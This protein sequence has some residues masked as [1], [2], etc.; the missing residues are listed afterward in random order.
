MR[1]LQVTDKNIKGLKWH[2]FAMLLPYISE[3]RKRISLAISFMVLAKLASVSLPFFLKY[4]VD[5]L[6][7]ETG[8]VAK[9][10]FPPLALVLAYGFARFLN[11][12]FNELRD[13]VFGRVTE[14]TMRKVGLKTFI[15]LHSLDLDF[16]LNRRT[17]GLS[18][19]IERG[20]NGISFLM[21]F[22]IFNIL[23]TL[24]EV[25]L[26]VCLLFY[27]YGIVYAL[28]TLFS[29]IAYVCFS[30]YATEW[31]TRFVR[32]E[33]EADSSS[34]TRAIDSLM[35]YE[36]V[37]YFTN[38]NHEAR[39]YDHELMFWE[40]ARRKN[41]LTL[42][43]LNAGQALI[44]AITMTTLLALAASEVIAKTMTIG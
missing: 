10:I 4:I 43:A 22:L 3:F 34:N 38:E 42:F 41:R 13:T 1:H 32:E 29:V 33:N 12:I 24:F 27:N 18:R 40:Q 9:F 6:D 21:R 8:N 37:K 7:P 36:T 16:H 25:L 2:V 20:I 17:G 44:I 15:H 31:R 23:P 5:G 26:V 19:D 30:I 35:N 11:V 14:H 39:M 28:I